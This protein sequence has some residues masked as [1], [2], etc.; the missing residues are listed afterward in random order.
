MGHFLS[1]ELVDHICKPYQRAGKFA[2]HFARGKLNR[3]PVFAHILQAGYIPPHARILDIGCGQ[4]LL[5]ALLCGMDDYTH[6]YSE[7][8]AEIKAVSV[9]GIE[10][11]LNDVIRAH[12][13]LQVFGSRI[14]IIHG[15]MRHIDFGVAD[16]VV[17]LDVLH[18]VPSNEQNDILKRVYAC[19]SSGGKLLLRVGDAAAG[20]PFLFSKWVDAVVF[21]F[22]GHASVRVYC[23]SLTEWKDQLEKIGFRVT[24]I[25]M[26][27]GTPFANI[28]LHCQ[29]P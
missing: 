6:R 10:L 22:R 12:Q 9:T 4:G 2:W 17:I 28:L 13:A 24:A 19:L 5:A 23:R 27:E 3:D 29:R 20:L 18:Y 21:A 1:P 26:H 16:V 25:P 15:D 8:K 14:Q 11:M 7:K